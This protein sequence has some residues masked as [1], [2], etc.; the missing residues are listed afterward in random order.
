MAKPNREQERIAR[1][2]AAIEKQREKNKKAAKKREAKAAW[3]KRRAD[4]D[5]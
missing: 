1:M 4:G 5:D 3:W 2:N